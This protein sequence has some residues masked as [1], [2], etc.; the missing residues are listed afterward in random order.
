[1][2]YWLE[3]PKKWKYGKQQARRHI[4]GNRPSRKI[5]GCQFPYPFMEA[6]DGG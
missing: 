2:M 3:K 5:S 4:S 6:V 1:V